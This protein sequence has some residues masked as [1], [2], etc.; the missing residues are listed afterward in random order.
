MKSIFSGSKNNLFRPVLTDSKGF[1][2]V[3]LR[4]FK[5]IC[6]I[7][8]ISA[9][10]YRQKK[11]AFTQSHWLYATIGECGMWSPTAHIRTKIA[12][13]TKQ[14]RPDLIPVCWPPNCKNWYARLGIICAPG[15]S[16]SNRRLTPGLG[17][18]RTQFRRPAHIIFTIVY[19]IDWWFSMG[20]GC[21]SWRIRKGR[22]IFSCWNSSSKMMCLTSDH[23]LGMLYSI[24]LC[25]GVW[26]SAKP[27]TRVRFTALPYRYQ[28]NRRF[29]FS[30]SLSS[31]RHLSIY[32]RSLL[33]C[34]ALSRF[35]WRVF[36]R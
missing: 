12:F 25:W 33:W 34:N 20:L 5:H 27:D 16:P 21:G 31:R 1:L 36:Q 24:V 35:H 11:V 4:S 9:S 10:F 14:F 26:T 2:R 30:S 7:R 15:Q 22:S 6:A 29:Q 19:W 13:Y 28:H 3:K 17:C 23:A 18:G 8:K 32:H